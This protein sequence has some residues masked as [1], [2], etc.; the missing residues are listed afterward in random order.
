MGRTADMKLLNRL[1]L[2]VAMLL[3]I[4]ASPLSAQR[5]W[6]EFYEQAIDEIGKGQLQSAERKLLEA[7]KLNTQ[8]G[9]RR[10]Y[11]MKFLEYYPDYYLGVIY[12]KTGRQKEATERFAAAAKQGVPKSGAFSQFDQLAAQAQKEFQAT[13]VA[14]NTAK[15]NPVT[16]D[17]PGRGDPAPPGRGDPA[18]TGRNAEATPPP[19]TPTGPTPRDNF[20]RLLG[21]ATQFLKQGNYASATTAAQ[22]AKDLNIDNSR[23]ETLQREIREAHGTSLARA[24]DAALKTRDEVAA[25]RALVTLST[26]VPDFSRLA[27]YRRNVDALALD[28]FVNRAERG[29]MQAYFEGNYQGAVKVINDA[30]G[31]APQL[32]PRALFYRACSLAAIALQAKAP[33]QNLLNRAKQALGAGIGPNQF[34]ADLQYISPKVRQALGFAGT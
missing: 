10:A 12:L 20:E 5:T 16:P 22:S 13:A 33:D 18:P 19:V 4:G 17:P 14:E 21:E 29:A 32:S 6:E 2:I 30:Q 31:K 24:V 7:K 26:A 9:R 27:D 25:T 1:S 23:V 11:G 34:R 15:P 8:P 3:T 28:L